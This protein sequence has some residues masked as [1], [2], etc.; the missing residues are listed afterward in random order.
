[1]RQGWFSAA[2]L[3]VAG[4]AMPVA[5]QDAPHNPN[6][7]PDLR[8]EAFAKL[9]YWPGYWVSEQYAGTT[10]GGS[11]PPRPAGSPALQRL[12]GFNAAWNDEGK[13]RQ[14]EAAR[15]RGGRKAMG[16]GFPMMMDAATPFQVVITP[17]ET[18]IVNAYGETRHIYTDGRAMPAAEDLWP[19]VWGTSIGR[20]DGATLIVETVQVQ[21]PYTYFHG[22]PTFSEQ[23]V[24]HE[25]IH[26][27]GDRLVTEFTVEDPVTLTAPFSAAITHVKEDAF[28]RMVQMDFAND[29]TGSEG[30]INTIEPPADE[31]EGG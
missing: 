3:L 11:A 26:M 22:G 16:W 31:R 15:T 9:P 10:I 30:G 25:R 21:M 20:W 2:A 29:R 4:I 24:Y 23:A 19:T 12:N 17:E 28:D 13:A 27:E 7:S 5:A 1:M 8:L 14:A 6:H 18:L